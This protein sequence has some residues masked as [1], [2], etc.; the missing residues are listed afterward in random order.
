MHDMIML[1]TKKCLSVVSQSQWHTNENRA[2]Q[3]ET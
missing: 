1:H 3:R 2:L